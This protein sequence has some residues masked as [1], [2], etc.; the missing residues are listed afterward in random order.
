[1]LYIYNVIVICRL[2]DSRCNSLNLVFS[3]GLLKKFT[4]GLLKMPI[5]MITSLDFHEIK[6]KN[7]INGL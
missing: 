7:S 2:C 6:K 5:N 1:L 3:T 4:T